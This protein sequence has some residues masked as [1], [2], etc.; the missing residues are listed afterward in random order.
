MERL[1][2]RVQKLFHSEWPLI[3]IL[4][5]T[6]IVR[7]PSLFE[8]LWYG[9]EAIYLTI[10][11]KILRGGLLYA[12]IFDHKTPGIYYLTAAAIRLF[13]G[14]VWSV[15]FLLMIW[16]LATFV[17]FFFL[18][19]RLLSKKVALAAT[20]ILAVLTSTPLIEGN[21]YNSE[22][23]MILPISL[24]ILA[25]LR[26]RFFIAGIFFSL[27]FLLKVPAMFDFA[28]FS[29]F[30]LFTIRKKAVSEILKNLTLL[31]AGFFVP[32]FLTSLY[33]LWQG[34]L[35][36]YLR[37]AFLF[38]ITYVGRGNSFI[39]THGLLV[40]KAL[41]VFLLVCCYGVRSFLRFQKSGD[42][43]FTLLDFLVL[44]LF[45]SFYAAVFGGRPYEH[46]LIQAVAPFSL[47]AAA[48]FFK[49]SFAKV[50]ATVL[51]VVVA[52]TFALGF[53]LYLHSS[54]Y[55]N[56]FKYTTNQIG[57]EQYTKT[58]NWHAA[59]NYA[60]ADFLKGCEKFNREGVCVEGRTGKGDSL[61][62]FSNQPAVYF[63]S[64]LDPASRYI[65]FFHIAGDDKA[66]TQTAK[67]I[68]EREPK[69]ILVE[70]PPPGN[71]P[72]LEKL[73]SSRYNL[74]A[75]YEDMAIYKIIKNSRL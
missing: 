42:T 46:Y 59:T 4:S 14:S 74:F 60:L 64:G 35:E 7:L 49:K 56:F 61:Y 55:T 32:I 57:F 22:I 30:V 6:F 41:P 19:K 71:F 73:L 69:Y 26:Q 68:S 44:W 5:L 70:K 11:Q 58:Y 24:G 65:T 9:D 33:F 31:L 38:N 12:D 51:L 2:L 52:L 10:G 3:A 37:S 20:A 66:K 25:G 27:A 75:F 17:A 34:A 48:S 54:Y 18:G 36:E 43:G 28:A 72:A 16:V 62:I 29:I 53:R 67:E 13:G 40:A 8:P 50:G 47:I 23:L 39:F 1:S 45:L 21:I 63:L 15:K